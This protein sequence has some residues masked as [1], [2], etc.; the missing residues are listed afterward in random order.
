MR[1]TMREPADD[2][3]ETKAIREL[4]ITEL[5]AISG[6]CPNCTRNNQEAGC[7]CKPSPRIP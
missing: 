7:L 4:T 2:A 1:E 6:G 5:E 3:I